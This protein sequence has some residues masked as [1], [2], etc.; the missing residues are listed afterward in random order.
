MVANNIA[1]GGTVTP[2]ESE[3]GQC[4]D[5]AEHARGS[6]VPDSGRAKILGGADLLKIYM[7]PAVAAIAQSIGNQPAE[8]YAGFTTNTPCCVRAL[9]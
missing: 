6:D 1:A 2:A 3:P 9:R 7:Q 4:A 5:R 8:L